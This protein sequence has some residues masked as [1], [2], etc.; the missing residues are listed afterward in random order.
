M[1][2]KPPE[3]MTD[4]E[5]EGLISFYESGIEFY[6]SSQAIHSGMIADAR[7]LAKK[8]SDERARREG[9]PANVVSIREGD[10]P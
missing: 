8:Y 9:P 1:I 3:Q 2:R 4:K 6:S 10:T 7:A 5:I